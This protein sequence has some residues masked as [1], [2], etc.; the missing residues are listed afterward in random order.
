MPP[1]RALVLCTTPRSG[2]TLVCALI[3]SAGN[4]GWPESWWR[5]EDRADYAADWGIADAAGRWTPQD[6]LAGAIRA[7]SSP[8]GSFGLRLQPPALPALIADLRALTPDAP[9][10]GA[11]SDAALMRRHFGPCAF[12][13]IRRRD[14]VA[15]AI[16]RLRAEASQIWHLDGEEP[17]SPRAEATYDAAK[18]DAW[19]TEAAQGN[20]AWEAWFAAEGITPCRMIYEDFATDA[21]AAVTAALAALG[22]APARPPGAPNRRMADAT[23][24][25][26]AAR[27]RAERGLPAP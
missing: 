10:A 19:R 9:T 14:D 8:D 17:D 24:A 2:S 22:M 5:S 3:R 25:G 12:L 26:W 11:E 20:A 1:P 6:Y 27:Y 21:P 13:Y 15:Q 23:S 4:A 16:S 7:G 18:I